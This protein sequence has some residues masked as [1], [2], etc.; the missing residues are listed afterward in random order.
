MSALARAAGRATAALALVAM[1]IAAPLAAAVP[2]TPDAPRA[3]AVADAAAPAGISGLDVAR[4]DAAFS[5]YATRGS[6]GCATG[7]VLGGRLA[8]GRG[9][10][11]ASLE[12]E[13]PIGTA[14]VFDLGSTSKQ[15]TAAMVALLAHDGRLSLDDPIRKFLPEIP[16]YGATVTIRHLL[17]HTSGL[18]DYTD[19]LALAGM[20]DEDLSTAADALAVLARQRGVNFA[21]GAEYRYCNSG[22]FLASIIVERAA[23]KSLRALARERLF[24]PLG[25]DHTLFF[26]DHALI[27]PRRA[28]GYAPRPGG[29]FRTAG[30]DWEQVGDGGVQ[31]SVEDMARWAALF[32]PGGTA[33]EAAVPA[34]WLRGVLETPGKLADG[35]PL[36]YGLGVALDRHR[37]LRVVRHGGAWAGYRAMLMRVPER[38]LAVVTLCNVGRAD[39]ATLSL[40][41]LDAALDALPDPPPAAPH[42]AT[43]GASGERAGWAALAGTYVSESLGETLVVA[44]AEGGLHLGEDRAALAALGDR[45]FATDDGD[46]E[47]TFAA[48]GAGLSLR[49]AGA[50]DP[51]PATYRRAPASGL[52]PADSLEGL[53][54]EYRS[55]EIGRGVTVVAREGAPRLVLAGGEVVDL[56]ALDRDLY[57]SDWGIVRVERD[58][59]GHPA[60]LALTNRGVVRLRFSR[61]TG[62]PPTPARAPAH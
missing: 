60:A 62:G 38:R 49:E 17:T 35:T 31:S 8:W 1:A 39:T 2:T 40:A 46:T 6:P 59:G 50:A 28:S 22:Y 45:R 57:G 4:I 54:G 18:R 33:R 61:V 10:G 34:G 29:G 12:H 58:A 56:E 13:V 27:V 32:D 7:I 23:G 15:I 44:F 19:L 21:P 48:D 24:A 30:S 11:M 37:G 25:M 41:V 14:T 55:D 5:A 16:D 42:P 9:Y 43:A 3:P 51:R 53:A 26:D 36:A 47:I 20:H 52:P